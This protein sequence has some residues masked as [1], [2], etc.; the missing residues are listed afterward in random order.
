MWKASVNDKTASLK[1]VQHKLQGKNGT[2]GP[3]TGFMVGIWAVLAGQAAF[4]VANVM[5]EVAAG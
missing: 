4:C 2:F 5:T 1:G 3:V